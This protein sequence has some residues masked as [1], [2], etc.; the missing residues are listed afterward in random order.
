MSH[1]SI[2]RLR[3]MCRA[4][5]RAQVA[6]VAKSARPSRGACAAMIVAGH[7]MSMGRSAARSATIGR[8]VLRYAARPSESKALWVALVR[9]VC[10]RVRLHEVVSGMNGACA[11]PR[12]L[13]G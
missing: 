6:N 8:V 13:H 12:G 5:A 3:R 2:E 10:L 7:A 1:P 9:C 4:P 11:A